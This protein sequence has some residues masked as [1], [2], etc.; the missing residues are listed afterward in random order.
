MGQ[1]FGIDDSHIY[2]DYRALLDT[3]D[4]DFVDIATAPAVHREQVL[5][6]AARHLPIF[7]QKPFATSMAEAHE[8]QQ[9][10]SA[11]GVRCIINENWRWRRWYQEIK[12]LIERGTIGKPHYAPASAA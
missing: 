1:E 3:E 10:C 6:V 7:C 5:A 8:M 4:L 11:G 12:A 9:A 2:A